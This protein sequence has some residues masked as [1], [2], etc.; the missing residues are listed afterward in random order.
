ME[1]ASK[2]ITLLL[3]VLMFSFASI[4]QDQEFLRGKVLD[5]KTGEPVVFA[6]VRILGKARGVIAYM[7]GSLLL[8]VKD[9]NG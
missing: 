7:E 4:A 6:T 2:G 1:R 9:K 8:F 3:G 5:Q